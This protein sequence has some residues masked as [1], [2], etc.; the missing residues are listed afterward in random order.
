MNN[1]QRNIS[2]ALMAMLFFLVGVP[3]HSKAVVQADQFTS[4]TVESPYSEEE[5]LNMICKTY[6]A[7]LQ[8]MSENVEAKKKELQEAPESR[9]AILAMQ[10]ARLEFN[11]NQVVTEANKTCGAK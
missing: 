8:W 4:Y 11:Y 9:K 6:A 3:Q 2:S 10:L 7:Q 5:Y 1:P